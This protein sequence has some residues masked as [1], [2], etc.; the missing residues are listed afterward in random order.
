M[1]KSPQNRGCDH[2]LIRF[3]VMATLLLGPNLLPLGVGQIRVRRRK[4]ASTAMR[5]MQH[6]EPAAIEQVRRVLA[7]P[8]KKT[9]HRLV[10][11]L[12][13]EEM[14]ALLDAPDPPRGW[15]FEIGRYCISRFVRASEFRN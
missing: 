14:Q 2:S 12:A 13:Q 4:I 11:Y 10:P 3:E 8:V 15:V 9:D 5:L 7:I 6:R 1:M